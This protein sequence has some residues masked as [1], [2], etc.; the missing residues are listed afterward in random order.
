MAAKPHALSKVQAEPPVDTDYDAICAAVTATAR[1]RWFLDE[2]AKRNRHSNTAEV[3]AAIARMETAVTG[4]RI[5]Q[6][7]REAHQEVQIELLEMA[8]TI[9]QTRAAV[10]EV[11]AVPPQPVDAVPAGGAVAPDVAAA[12]ERLR[13]IAW[14]IRACGIELPAAEQIGEIASAILKADALRGVGDQRAHKLAE[15]LLYLEHRIDRMLDSH[16]AAS[17]NATR[18]VADPSFPKA[19][20]RPSAPA[21]ATVAM[22]AAAMRPKAAEAEASPAP[23]VAEARA[24]AMAQDAL[25]AAEVADY[26]TDDDVVLTVADDT[27]ESVAP[28]P[29]PDAPADEAGNE[30]VTLE[31]DPPTPAMMPAMAPATRDDDD[32]GFAGLELEPLSV[33]TPTAVIEPR[34]E[35]SASASDDAG[36]RAD[37]EQPILATSVAATASAESDIIALQVDRDLDDLT[38]SAPDDV[39]PAPAASPQEQPVPAQPLAAPAARTKTMRVRP[40]PADEPAEAALEAS[41]QQARVS[42]AVAGAQAARAQLSDTLAAI[43]SELFGS[44]RPDA[45]TDAAA[46]TVIAPATAEPAAASVAAGPLAALM[47]MRAEER[48]ALFS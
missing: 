7:S 28:A 34:I 8:R 31:V 11:H 16:R 5:Q 37:D 40:E 12:A 22:I 46:P 19:G 42:A 4:E 18:P 13:Q 21:P 44:T 1:G 3:L 30:Q 27:P 6:A 20:D 41:P 24:A 47:A 39:I 29:P 10:T 9:A 25:A 32:T 15:A 45:A 17:G 23:A 36:S 48:I 43:E 14:T 26:P 33:T 35:S 38:E 2:Y